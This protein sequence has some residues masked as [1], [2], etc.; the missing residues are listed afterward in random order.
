MTPSG[1]ETAKFSKPRSGDNMVEKAMEQLL[2]LR[3]SVFQK[4][5]SRKGRHEK[6]HAAHIL[7]CV[8]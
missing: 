3:K 8:A 6:V 4:E 5:I 1:S 2:N 7:A